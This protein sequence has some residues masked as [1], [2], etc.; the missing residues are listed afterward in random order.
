MTRTQG[1]KNSLPG[2]SRRREAWT[3]THQGG[4]WPRLSSSPVSASM[5]GMEGFKMVPSPTTEPRPDPRPLGDHAPAADHHLVLDDHGRRLGRLEHPPDTHA[6]GEVDLLADLGAG[7]DGG[8]GVYHGAGPDPGSDVDEAG[9]ADHA[10]PEERPP[11]GRGPGYHPHP[12]GGVVLLQGEL[13]GELERPELLG[14]HGPETEQQQDGLLQPLVDDDLVG[15]RVDL[16]H[17]RSTAVEQVDGLG[18]RGQRLGVGRPQL[19][20]PVPQLFDLGLEIC[21][22]RRR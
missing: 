3:A 1:R 21:H 2:Y 14:L 13:V 15:G 10:V 12:R 4:T 6:A 20:R 19:G 17:P 22:V 8:P 9:H 18:H 5:T 7:S 11:P 16:G